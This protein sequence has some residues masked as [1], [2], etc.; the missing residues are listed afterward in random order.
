[1]AKVS[2]LEWIAEKT[3]KYKSAGILNQFNVE[4]QV[5]LWSQFEQELMRGR[6]SFLQNVWTSFAHPFKGHDLMKGVN[7]EVTQVTSALETLMGSYISLFKRAMEAESEHVGKQQ[8]GKFLV[9][10]SSGVMGHIDQLL[11]RCTPE[12]GSYH[13]SLLSSDRSSLDAEKSLQGKP[14][15]YAGIIYSLEKLGARSSSSI[16]DTVIEMSRLGYM[17]RCAE[18][19]NECAVESAATSVSDAHR[20]LDEFSDSAKKILLKDM[21][22]LRNI[23][24]LGEFAK[25]VASPETNKYLI[26]RVDETLVP[27][28]EIFSSTSSSRLSEA[29]TGAYALS[30]LV[31]L[32]DKGNPHYVSTAVLDYFQETCERFRIQLG[33]YVPIHTSFP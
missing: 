8:Y 29:S 27:Y 31:A 17:L 30:H 13:A 3:G 24:K 1:M 26:K 7:G 32:R 2:I 25:H 9:H 19:D 28:L 18:H 15:T 10:M 12:T 16:D 11:P 4:N 23:E 33:K 5:L 22:L 14:L 6:S 21:Y 20:L